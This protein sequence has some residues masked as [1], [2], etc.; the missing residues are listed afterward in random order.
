[1]LTVEIYLQS[2][3]WI[4]KINSS[5]PYYVVVLVNITLEYI[6]TLQERKAS[7]VFAYPTHITEPILGI[8]KQKVSYI[9][10]MV[11]VYLSNDK[12]FP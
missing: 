7:P 9:L 1:M 8:T 10:A 11:T 12:P 6:F 2:I 5:F 4:L 3:Y